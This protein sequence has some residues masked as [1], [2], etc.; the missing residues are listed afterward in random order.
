MDI[1]TLT[2]KVLAIY[3]AVSGLFLLFRGK[4]VPHMLK[5]FFDHSAVV[6]LTGIVL[7]FL[8][9]MFLIQN[10]VWDGSWRTLVTIFV[11][12]VAIKGLLYVFAPKF[13]SEMAIKK[14]KQLFSIYGVVSV[15][16]GV[17]FF[18]LK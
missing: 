9:S 18:F 3:L 7:I 12:L 17:Y 11:W 8:A 16:I 13:L 2:L 14:S 15:I 4:T 5:D 10:N 6:Y 1:S